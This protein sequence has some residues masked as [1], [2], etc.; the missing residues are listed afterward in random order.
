MKRILITLPLEER[1][2]KIF[3][4]AAGAE[5]E[6]VFKTGPQVTDA[7]LASVCA[8]I[9]NL[10]TS[11]LKGH[12]NLAWVQ[13]NTAG[14]A[15][16]AADGVLPES[17]I[18][19]NA[20]GAYGT[21]V[22]EHMLAMTFSL[23]RHFGPYVRNQAVHKWESAGRIISVEDSTIA[24]LGLGDIGGSYAKKVKALGAHVIGFRRNL[25]EKPDFLDEQYTL[26]S[27][28]EVLP[29]ADLVVMVLPGVPETHHIMNAAR[30]A[31]MK[32]GAYLINVGRG[33][34]VDPA[35]LKDALRSGHLGGAGLDVTQPEPLPADDDLWDFENVIIT[36]HVAGHFFLQKTFENI[37]AI[38]AGN[39]QAY[40]H[41]EKLTHIVNRSTG[42]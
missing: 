31:L 38:A 39:L 34:A 24:V 7:D 4:A 21:A 8:V 42:Y 1:H 32:E 16:Y 13:L 35:A 28:D 18:L 2:I 9:G 26:S 17:C 29:R 22:S 15:E 20:A 23:I 6:F 41:G 25:R 12:D 3:E 11:A 37:V 30:L 27:L 19:T 33:A 10:P 40:M 14:A 36:P 5:A